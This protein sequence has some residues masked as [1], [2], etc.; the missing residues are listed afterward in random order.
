MYTA[1]SQIPVAVAYLILYVGI[2]TAFDLVYLLVND[3]FPTIFLATS[4]GACNVVGRLVSIFSPTMAYAPEPIPMLTLIVFSAICI[5]IPMLLVKVDQNLAG[6]KGRTG[7]HMQ[8]EV[9]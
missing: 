4:Y 2:V 5:F 9:A 3:L 8:K 7:S 6:S 1:E